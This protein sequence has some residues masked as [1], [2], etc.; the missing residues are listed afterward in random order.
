MCKAVEQA[1][2]GPG[3]QVLPLPFTLTVK[4]IFFSFTF[5]VQKCICVATCV[6]FYMK[7]IIKILTK[8]KQSVPY[9]K[10]ENE[11]AGETCKIGGVR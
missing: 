1:L 8:T 5:S 11:R 2:T 10:K 6:C 9:P 3:T 4:G 7:E